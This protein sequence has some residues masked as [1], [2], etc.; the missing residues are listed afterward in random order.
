[1]T[2]RPRRRLPLTIT[3]VTCLVL[4]IVAWNAIRLVTSLLWVGPLETYAPQPGA[5][6]I[7]GSGLFWAIAGTL[8][9]GA[10]LRRSWWA[11]G[12]LRLGAAVYAAWVW[13]DRLMVQSGPGSNWIFALATTVALLAYTWDVTLDARTQA[14][15]GREAD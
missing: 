10:L 15:F 1:M 9:A 3:L 6:Y 8:V 13:F 11:L 5:A 7:G 2:L 12:A 4:I 14:H